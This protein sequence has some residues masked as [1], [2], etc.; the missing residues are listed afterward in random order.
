MFLSSEF[1]GKPLSSLTAIVKLKYSELVKREEKKP[2]VCFLLVHKLVF[3][4]YNHVLRQAKFHFS[5]QGIRQRK[6]LVQ[7][8]FL[9][10]E[11][12]VFGTLPSMCLAWA[13]TGTHAVSSE[14]HISM[15]VK[16]K[17]LREL[18]SGSGMTL[19]LTD[20]KPL[21]SLF[22]P[23]LFTILCTLCWAVNNLV[24]TLGHEIYPCHI[25]VNRFQSSSHFTKMQDLGSTWSFS[26]SF[27]NIPEKAL[28][29]QETSVN[30][31]P[32]I[33]SIQASL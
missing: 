14:P 3:L 32:L 31:N 13:G 6:E 28:S 20:S 18:S 4:V 5:T 29:K 19:Q 1:P 10:Q 9:E 21:P 26:S 23:A 16:K 27:I 8:S 17:R 30:Q 25:P 2:F 7:S 15:Q 24:S 11:S 33:L 12:L 22:H